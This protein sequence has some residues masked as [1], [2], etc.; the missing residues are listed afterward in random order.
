VE[1]IT[2]VECTLTHYNLGPIEHI[3]PGEGRVYHVCN[4]EI[5][6]FRTRTGQVYATQALCSHRAG[7]LADGLVGAGRVICPL[8]GYVF[9][10]ATGQP[11]ENSCKQLRTYS[12]TLNDA[13]EIVLT[14]N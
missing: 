8:H 7:P 5:A 4:N 3:P 2:A 10:L 1:S 13:N 14:L 9:E 11:V 6:I 12:V